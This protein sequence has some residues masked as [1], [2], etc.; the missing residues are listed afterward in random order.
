MN[1]IIPLGG[2]GKRFTDNGYKTPKPF[3]KVFNK[4]FIYYVIDSIKLKPEDDMY[5][6]YNSNL[7]PYF[8]DFKY[9]HIHLIK[10]HTDTRGAAE[11][12]NFG[13]K[14]INNNKRCLLLDG[15]IFYGENIRSYIREPPFSRPSSSGNGDIEGALFYFDF[16][17]N[18]IIIFV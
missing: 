10:L 8:K 4:E 16:N 2:I 12:I 6:I 11:T 7:D 5:I 3:I 18:S 9:K 14:Y 1:I 17:A 13:L 15:D